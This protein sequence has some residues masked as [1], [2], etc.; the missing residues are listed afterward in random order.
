MKPAMMNGKKIFFEVFVSNG[1][2]FI[3]ISDKEYASEGITKIYFLRRF[4]MKYAMEDFVK[5]CD[6]I[7]EM[8]KAKQNDV[9]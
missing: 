7:A 3:L 4:S 9:Y 8:N 5:Y 6:K 1:D 2:P